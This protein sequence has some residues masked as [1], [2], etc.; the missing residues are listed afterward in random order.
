MTAPASSSSTI[1]SAQSLDRFARVFAWSVRRELWEHRSVLLAPVAAVGLVVLGYLLSLGRGAAAPSPAPTLSLAA[2]NLACFAAIVSAGAAAA[3][4]CLG[5]L[6]DERRDRSLLFWRSLPVSDTTAVLAKL[7]VAVAVAP[8]VALLVAA[9]AQGLML[10]FGWLSLSGRPDRA[11]RL[12]AAVASRQRVVGMAYGI[13][14]LSV[15]WSPIFAWLLAVSAAARRAVP[16]WA[17]GLPL[18]LCL[19]ERVA[20]GSSRLWAVIVDRITGSFRAAFDVEGAGRTFR[21][22]DAD[23]ARFLASPGL[24]GGLAIAVALTVLAIRLRRRA[25]PI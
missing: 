5:A 24:W 1:R 25:E 17:L 14:T 22:G 6:Y 12:A 2:Y 9:V 8:L 15:W 11:A 4:H 19:L 16:M 3:F 7:T 20:L 13:L 21:I 23:P 10:G 18:G